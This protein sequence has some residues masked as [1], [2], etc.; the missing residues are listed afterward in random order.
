MWVLSVVEVRKGFLEENSREKNRSNGSD[1]P[2]NK[3]G[4]WSERWFG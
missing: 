2:D 1:N 4:A 3:P